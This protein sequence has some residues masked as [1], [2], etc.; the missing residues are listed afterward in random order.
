MCISLNHFSR[1]TEEKP[2]NMVILCYQMLLGGWE[3]IFH[4]T[5]KKLF[6][7][8]PGITLSK[9]NHKPHILKT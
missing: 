8:S 2:A 7:R 4:S 9:F 3:I 5:Y 1:L 6:A